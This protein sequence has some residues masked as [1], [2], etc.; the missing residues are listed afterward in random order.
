[1]F[2]LLIACLIGIYL[3]LSYMD[4]RYR[5]LP[6]PATLVALLLVLLLLGYLNRW[7]ALWGGVV[8]AGML[9]IMSLLYQQRAVSSARKVPQPLAADAAMVPEPE[10]AVGQ[11]ASL[12][13]RDRNPNAV[14]NDEFYPQ[15][16]NG[17]DAASS[18]R[19]TPETAS[20][21][22]LNHATRDHAISPKGSR[23]AP[24]S[25]IGMGDI[26]LVA[27]LGPVTLSYGW[28]TLLAAMWLAPLISL[29]WM[30]FSR[31]TSCAHGPALI[32]ASLFSIGG[33][34]VAGF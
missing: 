28:G 23:A 18:Q 15:N 11:Q 16:L 21:N 34:T 26:K 31:R 3:W 27:S 30:V 8:W 17:Y 20:Q 32:L 13:R 19:S 2:A 1:M 4:F 29:V 9:F 22:N 12:G 25:L 14:G 5:R 24:Q 6:N 33:C 10:A 7:D